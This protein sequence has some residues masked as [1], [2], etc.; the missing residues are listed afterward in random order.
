MIGTQLVP[1]S[2]AQLLRILLHQMIPNVNL[3][4]ER[5]KNALRCGKGEGKWESSIKMDKTK[6]VYEETVKLRTDITAL[7]E[8]KRN[9]WVVKTEITFLYTV[10]LV[11]K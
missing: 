8:T 7:T 10:V 1:G 3:L 6:E 5:T 2:D 4:V 11:N 9:Y